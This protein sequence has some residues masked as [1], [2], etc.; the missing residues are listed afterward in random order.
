MKSYLQYLENNEAILLM[1]LAGELP[2]QDLQEVEQMLASDPSFRAEL[3][4]LRQTQA[5][6][7]DSLESLDAL[8]RPP[9]PPIVAMSQVSDLVHDWAERRRQ[10]VELAPPRQ[11]IPWWRIST[12]AAAILVVGSYIWGVYHTLTIRGTPGDHSNVS[13]N[14]PSDTPDPTDLDDYSPPQASRGLTDQ[15]KVALLANSLED[16]ASNDSSNLHVVEV[17][18]VTS[19][20][21][22]NSASDHSS[23]GEP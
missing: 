4:M 12:A 10:P 23:V 5:L 17:A 15:E 16:S 13:M 2:A 21:T 18:A 22:E 19:S 20:D 6:A 7:Y 8:T 1:Y 11:P 14:A 9:V 3:E